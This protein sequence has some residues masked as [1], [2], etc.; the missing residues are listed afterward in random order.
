MASSFFYSSRAKVLWC[1]FVTAGRNCPIPGDIR[2]EVWLRLAFTSWHP[3]CAALGAPA[4]HGP[5]RP[6]E[7]LRPNGITNFYWPYFQ[8]PGVAKAEFERDVALSM[9]SLLGRV[10]SDPP[11]SMFIEAGKGFLAERK[12]GQSLPSWLNEDDLRVFAEA[13]R[14][15]GFRGGLNWYRNID[16]NWELTAPWQDAQ[17]HQR[18]LFI[19]GAKDPVI[20]GLLGGKRLAEMKRVLPNLKEKLIIE[21]AGHWIQQERP[22]EVNAALIRFLKETA[23]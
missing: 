17:I 20:T 4:H 19:A 14:R 3:I 23:G 22:E 1:C 8:A 6:L 21:G 13:Y 15:S 10:S 16:R 18:S 2:S 7:T 11:A 12:P 5:S 9:R